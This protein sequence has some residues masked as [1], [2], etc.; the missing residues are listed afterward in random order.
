MCRIV[1]STG[2]DRE[3]RGAIPLP[4]PAPYFD[5][6]KYPLE[7]LQSFTAFAVEHGKPLQIL[8]SVNS[9]LQHFHYLVK[10][11]SL[12]LRH[13]ESLA[14]QGLIVTSNYLPQRAA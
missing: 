9:I 5:P 1:Q 11:E 2:T 8:D 6:L 14:P 12:H 3:G 4:G 10:F 7:V 13:K